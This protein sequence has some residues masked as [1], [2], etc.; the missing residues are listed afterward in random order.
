MSVRASVHWLELSG[1]QTVPEERA[2]VPPMTGAC[3]RTSALSPE[4]AAVSAAV[5]P[6]APLPSTRRSTAA[7]GPVSLP[8]LPAADACRLTKPP[9]LR[10]NAT[11][12]P[13]W[14]KHCDDVD[15]VK[16]CQSAPRLAC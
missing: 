9:S 13:Q 8:P 10:H 12:L 11:T 6:P 14:Q 3:S 5:R 4:S 2:E 15:G 1:N 7:G 16:R